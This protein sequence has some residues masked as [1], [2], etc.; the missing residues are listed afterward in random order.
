MR[1]TLFCVILG[2]ILTGLFVSGI[3][4]TKNWDHRGGWSDHP[5]IRIEQVFFVITISMI[6]L[7]AYELNRL[8]KHPPRRRP[9]RRS[10]RKHPTNSDDF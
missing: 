7:I 9:R 3:A 6:P 1:R 8:E 10:P 5:K 2:L 4:A